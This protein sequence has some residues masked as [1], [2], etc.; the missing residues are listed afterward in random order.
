MKIKL[1]SLFILAILLSACGQATTEISASEGQYSPEI[2]T[3]VAQALI[4]AV[5]PTKETLPT[6]T[7]TATMPIPTAT[8]PPTQTPLTTPS[9]TA[10]PKTFA[11]PMPYLTNVNGY[12]ACDN[13]IYISD[14][15]IKDGTILMPEE[16]FKKIWRLKNTGT[17]AWRPDYTLIFVSGYSMEGETTTINQYV[18]PGETAKISVRLIAP[19]VDGTY[20]GYWIL[21][22]RES[23][24]F[25]E[26]IWVQIVVSEDETEEEPE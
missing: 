12:S 17:C 23:A 26:T 15:T 19:D 7:A 10:Q 1:L 11:T 4:S 24:V 22:N 5:T 18:A 8:L 21:T 2:Y 20:A 6:V 3:Q 13:S 14:I 9:L 16:P 25:G